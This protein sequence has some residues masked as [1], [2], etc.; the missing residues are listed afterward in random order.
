MPIITASA[1]ASPSPTTRYEHRAQERL[2]LLLHRPFQGETMARF[3]AE[4]LKATTAAVLYDNGDTYSTGVTS[5]SWRSARTWASK[6]FAEES[7]ASGA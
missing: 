3:A 4:E 6:W 7:Y 1:T 5:T 2:P